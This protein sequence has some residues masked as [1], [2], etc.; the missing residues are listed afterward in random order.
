MMALTVGPKS[1]HVDRVAPQPQTQSSLP[2]TDID[3]DLLVKRVENTIMTDKGRQTVG[4]TPQELLARSNPGLFTHDIESTARD[5][6]NPREMYNILSHRTKSIEDLAVRLKQELARASK[7]TGHFPN[8]PRTLS[9]ND[10]DQTKTGRFGHKAQ[11]VSNMQNGDRKLDVILLNRHNTSI[12]DFRACSQK[13][14]EQE[15][16]VNLPRLPTAGTGHPDKDGDTRDKEKL[17]LPDLTE[18]HKDGGELKEPP[19]NTDKLGK[20]LLRI[21]EELSTSDSKLDKWFSEMPNEVFDKAQRA[22]M[23]NTIRERLN[24]F[25][26]RRNR[27]VNFPNQSVNVFLGSK[28]TRIPNT[29]LELRVDSFGKHLQYDKDRYK[30][31]LKSVHH[32]KTRELSDVE[33]PS[34][35]DELPRMALQHRSL[36]TLALTKAKPRL[37]ADKR[38]RSRKHYIEIPTAKGMKTVY[39]NDSFDAYERE[40]GSRLRQSG[41]SNYEE[42]TERLNMMREASD[43][44]HMRN[45]SPIIFSEGDPEQDAEASSGDRETTKAAIVNLAL[46]KSAPKSRKPT[47]LKK[48]LMEIERHEKLGHTN[49]DIV[50]GD[51]DGDVD[52]D[53]MDG[54]IAGEKHE[55]IVTKIPTAQSSRTSDTKSSN[56][57]VMSNKTPLKRFNT[58]EVFAE[59]GRIPEAPTINNLRQQRTR[60]EG[61]RGIPLPSSIKL[62]TKHQPH[63]PANPPRH[64]VFFREREAKKPDVTF[65]FEPGAVHIYKN[66]PYQLQNHTRSSERARVIYGK[67]NKEP[68][69]RRDPGHGRRKDDTRDGNSMA[70]MST[71][72][73]AYRSELARFENR[74]LDES[75]CSMSSRHDDGAK[76]TMLVIGNEASK[77]L[78]GI[79]T[80]PKAVSKRDV[81]VE[82]DIIGSQHSSEANSPEHSARKSLDRALSAAQS[83]SGLSDFIVDNND[84]ESLSSDGDEDMQPTD[85]QSV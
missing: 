82:T 36:T 52:L 73:D 63:P 55:P 27:K 58:L 20:N 11:P 14:R 34:R 76:N 85:S 9:M 60:T 49:G 28:M 12:D 71:K 25:Q 44:I 78:H 19:V 7:T 53:V 21:N 68:P 33:R 38:A 22:L 32:L 64:D 16:N 70:T 29:Y 17:E 56:S 18:K 8:L 1:R 83:G 47:H 80:A 30:M 5:L 2:A 45:N 57:S 79:S 41:I 66:N 74:A 46:A 69:V 61:L 42:Y 24:E 84:G 67:I 13:L 23:E 77:R 81:A 39:M 59:F 75:F 62:D 35:E 6:T 51:S 3:F 40:H 72:L 48:T 37:D 15:N 10:I 26:R 43:I 4:I 50:H 65:R 54:M 31:H